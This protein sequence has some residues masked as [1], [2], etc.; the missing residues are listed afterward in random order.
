MLSNIPGKGLGLAAKRIGAAASVSA[1]M[2]PKMDILKGKIE[3]VKSKASSL[4]EG[5]ASKVSGLKSKVA[6][7]KAGVPK[8]EGASSYGVAMKKQLPFRGGLGKRL[9]AA[10]RMG[11]RSFMKQGSK[12][13]AVKN[14]MSTSFKKPEVK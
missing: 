8:K 7:F 3:S 10:A 6:E 12:L 2:N 9:P 11:A 4:K 14:A 5:I 1:K 13:G